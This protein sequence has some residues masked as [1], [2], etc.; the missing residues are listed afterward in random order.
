[1]AGVYPGIAA[2]CMMAREKRSNKLIKSVLLSVALLQLIAFGCDIIENIYLL[3][4]LNK[5]V[6]ENEFAFFH[7]L[8]AI[9]WI[10]A[11]FGALIAI[12]LN[13]KKGLK[14]NPIF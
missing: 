4:W 7:W 6:I 8:V 11:I 1:M 14:I 10:L 13:L 3:N 9:K 5:P 12:S 2:L